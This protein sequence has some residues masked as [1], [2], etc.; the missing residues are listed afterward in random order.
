[1]G[2]KDSQGNEI[3]LGS[4]VAFIRSTGRY[5]KKT[6]LVVGEVTRIRTDERLNSG[7]STKVT[8]RFSEKETRKFY[9]YGQNKYVE[10]PQSE[11]TKYTDLRSSDTRSL[12]IG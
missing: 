5:N 7:S 11:I 10:G 4:K 9:D 1:M 3:K 6:K 12:V 2:L 8:V